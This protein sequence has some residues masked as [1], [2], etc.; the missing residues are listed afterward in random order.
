M[1]AYPVSVCGGVLTTILIFLSYPRQQSLTPFTGWFFRGS[2]RGKS[3]ACALLVGLGC[4][5]ASLP[6][7]LEGKQPA[8]FSIYIPGMSIIL[9]PLSFLCMSFAIF[10]FVTTLDLLVGTHETP[11]VA[12]SEPT[13]TDDSGNLSGIAF[14]TFTFILLLFL[15]IRLII[16]KWFLSYDQLL[17]MALAGVTGSFFSWSLWSI[18][19]A[20]GANKLSAEMEGEDDL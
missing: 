3:I 19:M 1:Y 13:E 20:Q 12:S 11:V 16:P 18:R 8:Y 10:L 17:V 4:L 14:F 7:I 5:S 9:Y 2:C 6:L 15:V